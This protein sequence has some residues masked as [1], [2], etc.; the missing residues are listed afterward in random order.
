MT[1]IMQ[2]KQKCRFRSAVCFAKGPNPI[3]N[4][5]HHQNLKHHRSPGDPAFECAF[6]TLLFTLCTRL[7]T[8]QDSDN[9]PFLLILRSSSDEEYRPL[10]GNRTPKGSRQL[11]YSPGTPVLV[12]GMSL[13]TRK[14]WFRKDIQGRRGKASYHRPSKE[15]KVD[16]RHTG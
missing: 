15:R 6:N 2:Q 8:I 5:E 12:Y 10:H 7:G 4:S 9:E 1:S 16:L 3:K 14:R 13:R 11:S